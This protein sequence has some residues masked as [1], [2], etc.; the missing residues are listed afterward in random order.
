MMEISLHEARRRI[1]SITKAL[2]AQTLSLSQALSCCLVEDISL[3]H[4]KPAFDQSTRDGFALAAPENNSHEIHPNKEFTYS[5]VGEIAAGDVG[6][7][8]LQPGTAYRIMTGAKPPSGVSHVI[9]FE[10]VREESGQVFVPATMIGDNS[11]IRREGC[12]FKSGELVVSKGVPLEPGSLMALAADGVEQVNVHRRPLVLVVCTGTELVRPGLSPGSVEKVS[13]N[14][15]L[16][17]SLLSQSGV[18]CRT[19]DPV[20]DDIEELRNVLRELEKTGPDMII[21]TGGMGPGKYDNLERVFLSLDGVVHYNRLR[22]RPGK[23]TMFGS[24]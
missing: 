2:P 8:S 15:V 6:Q 24:L 11:Y 9:P 18:D 5:I 16:L 17:A 1:R 10:L 7:S 23:A 21:T 14:G 20:S 13:S 4:G 12:E 19:V 3:V 22:M